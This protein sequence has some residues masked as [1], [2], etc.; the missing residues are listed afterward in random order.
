M[1]LHSAY[2]VTFQILSVWWWGSR[3][4]LRREPNDSPLAPVH[5]LHLTS[6]TLCA[7]FFAPAYPSRL[8]GLRISPFPWPSPSHLTVRAVLRILG[9]QRVSEKEHAIRLH[10]W[11][12]VVCVIAVTLTGAPICDSSAGGSGISCGAGVRGGDSDGGSG[13]VK[14]GVSSR[15]TVCDVISAGAFDLAAALA[16][17]EEARVDIADDGERASTTPSAGVRWPGNFIY[18]T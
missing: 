8:S 7:L 1:L 10:H 4:S 14:S 3:D 11:V 16:K 13:P 5:I 9:P 12:R 2:N 15:S 18:V 17:R 6:C